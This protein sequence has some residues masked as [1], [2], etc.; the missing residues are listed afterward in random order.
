RCNIGHDRI[1]HEGYIRDTP[2]AR[3][4]IAG[5]ARVAHDHRN[6]SQVRTMA[7]RWLDPDL[8][9]D[10]TDRECIE[11]AIAQ[12]NSKRRALEGGECDLVDDGLAR[13]GGELGHD[14]ETGRAP[15]KPGMHVARISLPLPRHR[16]PILKCTH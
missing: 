13:T 12:D 14:F 15:Q 6:E 8:G 7:H 5:P 3:L 4:S 1:R 9:R 11:T 2:L 10:A 16:L